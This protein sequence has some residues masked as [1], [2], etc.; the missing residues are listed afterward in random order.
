MNQNR[1]KI[2]FLSWGVVVCLAV[3][4]G[5]LLYQKYFK[6]A[7]LIEKENI[8]INRERG[9]SHDEVTYLSQRDEEIAK[10]VHL[11]SPSVVS[12]RRN[13]ASSGDTIEQGSGVIITAS[14]HVLTNYH[15]VD[16]ASLDQTPIHIETH[17]GR[18]LQGKLIKVD[19][20]LDLALIKIDSTESF[21][22]IA[23]GDSE[24]ARVGHKVFAFGN[25]YGLG[26]SFSEGNISAKNRFI[27]ELQP[28]LIQMTA[29]LN[30]GQS[31]G[32]LVNIKGEL[33]G[34]NSSIYSKSEESGFQGI[35]FSIPSNEVEESVKSMMLGEKPVRG[36][37]GV[38]LSGV[39]DSYRKAYSYDKKG[40][41]M[42]VG[43]ERGSPAY[44]NGIKASDV[45]T[46]FD[47]KAITEQSHLIA[48]LRQN[49]NKEVRLSVWSREGEK[50]VTVKL[51]QALLKKF[52][53]DEESEALQSDILAQ[54][55]FEVQDI[56]IAEKKVYEGVKVKRVLKGSIAEKK[57]IKEGDQFVILNGQQLT[58]ANAFINLFRA[59]ARNRDSVIIAARDK[60]K[61]YRV[62]LPVLEK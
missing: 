2:I 3:A 19:T 12:I 40:G 47:G 35:A 38:T 27:S 1:K 29:P 50:E 51:G 55:G 5:V 26:V 34:I 18:L 39:Y 56:S 52:K 49:A 4:F 30:P 6:H 32:P 13:N 48:L 15:V 60:V 42:V 23:F 53:G 17:D 31:G 11:V 25:P 46:Q 33:V 37:L 21:K 28:N 14:G 16:S 36:Y 24:G 59:S 9:I 62:I 61:L 44:K 43:V 58:V 8:V 22:P 57:G 45:I 41:A 20:I 10:I 54:Y 7:P